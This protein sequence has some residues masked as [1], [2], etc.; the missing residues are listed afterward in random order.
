MSREAKKVLNE[1]Y[2]RELENLKSLEPNDKEYQESLERIAKLN[3]MMNEDRQSKTDCATKVITCLGGLAVSA[4]GLY[5][6]KTLA[7][8]VLRFEKDDSISSFTGR[9][10]IGNWL[11][12]IK[13]K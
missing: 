5:I 13:V 10:I 12:F 6:S 1:A 3:K 2:D 8:D 9:S 4:G 7:Y 11:K